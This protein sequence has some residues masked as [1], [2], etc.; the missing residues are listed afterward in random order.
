MVESSRRRRGHVVEPKRTVW[1]MHP[2]L[3]VL[4][5]CAG[6]FQ[7][8]GAMHGIARGCTAAHL[9]WAAAVD[10]C[11]T[12]FFM[13]QLEE[14]LMHQLARHDLSRV[15]WC[16]LEP[17]QTKIC[18]PLAQAQLQL[19]HALHRSVHAEP[20]HA[21]GMLLHV[22]GVP[23]RAAEVLL[24]P[25]LPTHAAAGHS[26]CPLQSG[27]LQPLCA[28]ALPIAILLRSLLPGSLV[29]ARA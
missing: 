1:S 5:A 4:G 16:A 17:W 20:A 10:C 24:E 7:P 23:L 22:S 8:C 9:H 25:Y 12:L 27:P 18:R 29:S 19:E 14:H 28:F 15:V 3:V 13:Q 21:P 6:I 11:Q 2:T 26:A